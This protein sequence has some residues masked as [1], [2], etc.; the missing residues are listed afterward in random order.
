MY[1]RG[2]RARDDKV[3]AKEGDEEK[4]NETVDG[5][6]RRSSGGDGRRVTARGTREKWFSKKFTR[7]IECVYVYGPTAVRRR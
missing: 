4:A 1:V 3:A 5:E 7:K 2:G 6:Y